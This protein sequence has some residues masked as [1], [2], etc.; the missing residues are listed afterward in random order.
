[1]D[2]YNISF[3]PLGRSNFGNVPT[4]YAFRPTGRFLQPDINIDGPGTTSIHILALNL[5]DVRSQTV[6]EIGDTSSTVLS[7]SSTPT[8]TG[9]TP[10]DKARGEIDPNHF[11]FAQLGALYVF[12]EKCE[13]DKVYDQSTLNE[14]RWW[15]NGF[16]VVVRL[17]EKGVPGAVYTLYNHGKQI[18]YTEDDEEDDCDESPEAAGHIPGYLHPRCTEG[19]KFAKVADSVEALGDHTKRFT[20]IP[21]TQ[22][23]NQIVRATVWQSEVNYEVEEGEK[24]W[25]CYVAPVNGSWKEP[26]KPEK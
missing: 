20:F 19:F 18:E 25:D 7:K 14:G 16:A 22:N 12:A 26:T 23:E 1:M 4:Y 21:I 17:S 15:S 9:E 11:V 3:I 2:A 6:S 13:D 8:V 10:T 5:T 24:V